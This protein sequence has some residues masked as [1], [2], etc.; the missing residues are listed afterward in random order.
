VRLSDLEPVFVQGLRSAAPT[1]MPLFDAPLIAAQRRRVRK[2]LN[3]R[4]ENFK[5]FLIK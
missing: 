4:M 5:S 3:E 1:V 2:L